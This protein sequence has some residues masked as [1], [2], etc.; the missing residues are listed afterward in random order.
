MATRTS[1]AAALAIMAVAAIAQPAT[2]QPAN[3]P[4][5]T[6]DAAVI[7]RIDPQQAVELLQ[8][9]GYRAS[10]THN[11][12]RQVEIETRMAGMTVYVTLLGCAEGRQCSSLQ[13]R[14]TANLPF[15]G[16]GRDRADLDAAMVATN[17]WGHHRR[18][19]VAYVYHSR[20]AGE[21]LVAF[22]TDHALFP[23]TT[24]Q[25][26]GHTIRN[27]ADLAGEFAAFMRDPAN[28]AM[29]NS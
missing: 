23:G 16:L 18:Y 1:T 29:P 24:R 12:A 6:G 5:A 10:I 14:L 22:A 27:Y 13:L 21:H 15:F 7:T 25:A 3:A 11:E 9:A 17:R 26:I 19:T 20:N 28:R 4:A 2:A 8:E